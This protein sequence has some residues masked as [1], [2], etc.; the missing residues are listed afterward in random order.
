MTAMA[1]KIY[2]RNISGLLVSRGAF[3]GYPAFGSSGFEK[4]WLGCRVSFSSNQCVQIYNV[5]F[6]GLFK[7]WWVS[8]CGTKYILGT[9]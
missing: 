1:R 9:S 6:Q 7:I 2:Y 5:E 4:W 8:A 3:C